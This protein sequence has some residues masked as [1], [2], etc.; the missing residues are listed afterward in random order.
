MQA[1]RQLAP[2]LSRRCSRGFFVPAN[3]DGWHKTSEMNQ[4]FSPFSSCSYAFWAE[5]RHPLRL[6][7]IVLPA[8]TYS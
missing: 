1:R 4:P 3:N 8:H 6:F 2:F 7:I 5:L